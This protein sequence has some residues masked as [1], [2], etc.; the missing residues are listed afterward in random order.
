MLLCMAERW[1]CIDPASQN[2]ALV[3]IF[4][5]FVHTAVKNNAL[6]V[7]FSFSYTMGCVLKADPL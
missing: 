5:I 2:H 1:V 7:T 4:F 3:Q 6:S